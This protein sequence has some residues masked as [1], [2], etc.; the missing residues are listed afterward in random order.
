MFRE[1][2]ARLRELTLVKLPRGEQGMIAF[3]IVG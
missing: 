2:D 3:R 1:I